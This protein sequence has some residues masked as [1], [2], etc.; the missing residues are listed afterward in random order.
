MEVGVLGD[1]GGVHSTA[2][3]LLWLRCGPGTIGDAATVCL[4][5]KNSAGTVHTGKASLHY[6]RA[7]VSPNGSAG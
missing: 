6:G 7:C 3:S 2:D 4:S 5:V 1:M